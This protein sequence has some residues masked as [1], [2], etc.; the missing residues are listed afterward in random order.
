[1][2]TPVKRRVSIEVQQVAA[3]PSQDAANMGGPLRR[4]GGACLAGTVDRVLNRYFINGE[5]RAPKGTIC[6]SCRGP[7]GD[8]C[9]AWPTSGGS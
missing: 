9:L 4:P 5:G 7:P 1:M 6:S 8:T 2:P 3:E